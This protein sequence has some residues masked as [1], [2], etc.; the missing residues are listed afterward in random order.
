MGH[1]PRPRKARARVDWRGHPLRISDMTLDKALAKADEMKATR[2]A[3]GGKAG[4]HHYDIHR[5]LE[6]LAKEIRHLRRKPKS[7]K[8]DP[9]PDDA[10]LPD[11]KDI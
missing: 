10:P 3:R 6:R 4:E 1:R 8:K 5:A 9:F 7:R 2:V 11:F